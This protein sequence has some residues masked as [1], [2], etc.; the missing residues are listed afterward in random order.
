MLFNTFE[1]IVNIEIV[2]IFH[3]L[4]LLTRKICFGM[5]VNLKRKQHKN[6]SR[7]WKVDNAARTFCFT[8]I[9]IQ[10]QSLQTVAK[11]SDSLNHYKKGE[12]NLVTWHRTKLYKIARNKLLQNCC[13]VSQ[14]DMCNNHNGMK[15]LT[16]Q[17]QTLFTP[18][19]KFVYI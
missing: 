9:I 8:L 6:S 11:K 3:A 4:I 13:R 18:R 1:F 2:S 12:I 15:F 7:G 19:N 14:P 17:T 16:Y 10:R 5:S